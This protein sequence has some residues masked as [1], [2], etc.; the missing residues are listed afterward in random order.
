[1]PQM[2]TTIRMSSVKYHVN[3][4]CRYFTYTYSRFKFRCTT[5][6]V[7]PEG[8][9]IITPVSSVVPITFVIRAML[10]GTLESPATLHINISYFV[11]TFT[12]LGV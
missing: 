7:L 3:T 4:I 12:Q 8:D 9:N 2:F 5:D 6:P 1:M 10:S 11:G